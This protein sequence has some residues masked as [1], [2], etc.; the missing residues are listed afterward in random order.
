MAFNEWLQLKRKWSSLD[1][2]ELG[3][4]LDLSLQ[5]FSRWENGKGLPKLTP[6]QMRLLCQ[7]LDCS[8][9]E[10][11]DYQTSSEDI[12]PLVQKAS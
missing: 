3:S 4:A 12:E 1:Q 8:L 2:R 7:L 5:A 10:L 11:V 9:D 6:R